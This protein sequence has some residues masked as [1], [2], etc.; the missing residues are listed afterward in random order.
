MQITSAPCKI[1]PASLENS[2]GRRGTVS[3][4]MPESTIPRG[5][6]RFPGKFSGA[7][8]LESH[9]NS[10]WRE[11]EE[12]IY[13]VFFTL[14]EAW[15][16]R[17][18]TSFSLSLLWTIAQVKKKKKGCNPGR[19]TCTGEYKNSCSEGDEQ[20]A[21]RFLSD[22]FVWWRLRIFSPEKC[23]CAHVNNIMPL[24]SRNSKIT[25]LWGQISEP[26]LRSPAGNTLNVSLLE[27][28]T[29]SWCS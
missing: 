12:E 5:R 22:P 1:L 11:R 9:G 27:C 8:S 29:S 23:A 26:K 17:C 14:S 16:F 21:R 3:W 20:R 6:H 7:H 19:E 28:S 24:F 4:L 13:I 10:I 2:P 25:S 18:S 15:C